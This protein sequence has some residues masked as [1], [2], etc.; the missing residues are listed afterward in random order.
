[1]HVSPTLKTAIFHS[2]LF[3]QKA[4]LSS[5]SSNHAGSPDV[6]SA[7]QKHHQM[8]AV[9]LH[10]QLPPCKQNW[11]FVFEWISLLLMLHFVSLFIVPVALCDIGAHAGADVQT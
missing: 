6:G 2:G 9:Q 1:M 3:K 7:G 5:L 11:T 8:W 4:T 10:T